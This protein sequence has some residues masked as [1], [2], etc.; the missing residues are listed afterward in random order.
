MK[1][2]YSKM[3][4][5]YYPHVVPNLYDFLTSAEHKRRYYVFFF[6][7]YYSVIFRTM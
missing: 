7:Y 4:I 3:L 1:E 6:Y 2:I 5:I